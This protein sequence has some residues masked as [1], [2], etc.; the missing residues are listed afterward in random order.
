MGRK[1]VSASVSH[2]LRAGN[3]DDKSTEKQKYRTVIIDITEL[4]LFSMEKNDTV[5]TEKAA[6]WSDATSI[7]TPC[8]THHQAAERLLV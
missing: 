2:G 5:N 1:G 7:R 3:T 8:S 6:S 4:Y